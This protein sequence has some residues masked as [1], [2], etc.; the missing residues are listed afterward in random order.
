MSELVNV[1]LTQE[2]LGWKFISAYSW[3]RKVDD[4]SKPRKFEPISLNKFE[5]NYPFLEL[6]NNCQLAI[7]RKQ[8]K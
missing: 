1:S 2:F 5:R 8:K 3:S 4:A 7:D 6:E